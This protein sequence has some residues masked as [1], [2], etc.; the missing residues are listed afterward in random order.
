MRARNRGTIVN[1]GSALSYRAIPLQSAYCG[2]KFAVRGF[3][4]SLRSELLHDGVSVLVAP[5][6]TRSPDGELG[7]FK[8]GPF[9]M[10]MTAGS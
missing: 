7:T 6:G 8:K 10:A 2:A 4:D 9:R 3:T 5:E 1:I